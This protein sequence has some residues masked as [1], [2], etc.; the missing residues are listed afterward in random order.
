MV[1]RTLI[2]DTVRAGVVPSADDAFNFRCGR[3]YLS[4]AYHSEPL[5]RCR[6]AGAEIAYLP[7]GGHA[8]AADLR[9]FANAVRPKYIV[10]VHGIKWD[11]EG[12]WI[13]LGATPADAE[14]MMVD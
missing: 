14:C 7:Y 1:R 12:L 11:E 6:S 4:E 10:P 8:S 2:R 5:E 3:D 9:V 13:W